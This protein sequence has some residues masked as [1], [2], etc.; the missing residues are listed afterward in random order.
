MKP[1]LNQWQ[2]RQATV[3]TNLNLPLLARFREELR[4]AAEARAE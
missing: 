1:S 4:G 3:L 2:T